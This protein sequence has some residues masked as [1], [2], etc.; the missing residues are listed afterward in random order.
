M[1]VEEDIL[2]FRL[3]RIYKDYTVQTILMKNYMG[4]QKL[5]NQHMA[6]Y[7]IT[8]VNAAKFS[9]QSAVSMMRISLILKDQLS[10]LQIIKSYA[11][12]KMTVI[13]EMHDR[14]SYYSLVFVEFMEFL[15]R[16]ANQLYG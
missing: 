4:L 13:D 5:Y 15:C 10:D 11:V 3:K 16:V 9:I 1:S 12:S 2:G 8:R 7:S 14:G 6:S